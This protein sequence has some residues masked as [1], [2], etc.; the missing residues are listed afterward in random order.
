MVLRPLAGGEPGARVS[1]IPIP[2]A[3][4][5]PRGGNVPSI[6]PPLTLD[7]TSRVALY[8]QIESQLREAILDGRLRPGVVLPGI[9]AFAR[10][11][12]V[13]AV[14]VMTAYDQL[15]AEGFLEPRPGVGTLVA[16]EILDPR[17]GPRD[18]PR[19]RARLPAPTGA[20]PVRP[21]FSEGWDAAEYDFRT[22]STNL[23]LFPVR[24]WERLVKAAWRDLS[25]P[26]GSLATSY[27]AT[28][29]DP[30]LR[31]QLARYLGASRAVH[32][33]AETIVVTAGAQAAMA[34]AA[35]LW[36]GPGRT[37]AVE[38]PGSP[39]LHRTFAALGTRIAPVPVDDRGLVVGRLPDDASAVLVT[40][41]WQYPRGGTLPVARRIQLLAW[42]AAHDALVI[43]DDCDSELR[44]AGHPLPSLQ[45]L[46]EAGRVLYVGTFSKVLFPG[47]RTG[48]AVVPLEHIDPFVA[49]LEALYRG[50]G[51]LEQRTLAR[52]IADGHFHRHL[53]RLRQV[54]AE[55]QGVALRA[56]ERELGAVVTVDPAPAGTHLVVRIEQPSVTAD[57]L[58][59]RA[60]RLGV[61]IEPLRLGQPGHGDSSSFLLH[62]ARHGAPALAAGIRRLG[63]A[64]RDA[65]REIA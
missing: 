37:L 64:F 44:Y 19:V 46:D 36:L 43:E 60:A 21:F 10:R 65:Q 50:P 1:G 7:R 58:A 17:P 11:L 53:A 26:A 55:R 16:P 15:T 8:R 35:Q 47:L 14:T 61:A 29:G 52:F 4:T 54:F 42:A 49:R 59:R 9:R 20:G 3:E 33:T 18:R 32:A 31:D 57:E 62:Y 63:Q 22:G 48:Y 24:T 38:D 40:P 34:A 30:E 41:S 39:N 27:V 51:A 2:P 25:G 56:L 13:A 6:D 12:G 23:D 5:A 28:A 45:G